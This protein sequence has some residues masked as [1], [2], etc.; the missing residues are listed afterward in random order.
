MNGHLRS[1][2]GWLLSAI[3][4]WGNAIKALKAAALKIHLRGLRHSKAMVPS[5]KSRL[6][7]VQGEDRQK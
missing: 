5:P 2:S 1:L 3:E 6:M 4:G 7:R